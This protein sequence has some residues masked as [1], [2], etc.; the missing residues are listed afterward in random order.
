MNA[1]RSD[2]SSHDRKEK[3]VAG[4]FAGKRG[5]GHQFFKAENF[6]KAKDWGG[7]SNES[8]RGRLWRFSTEGLRQRG[9]LNIFSNYRESTHRKG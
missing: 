6:E 1:R 9:S 8:E 3:E 5:Y 7:R 4:I 2:T